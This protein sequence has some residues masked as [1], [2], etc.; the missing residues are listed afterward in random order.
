[1]FGLKIHAFLFVWSNLLFLYLYL[2]ES[3][4]FQEGEKPDKIISSK[5]NIGGKLQMDASKGNTG[6]FMNGREITKIELR[7]LKVNSFSPCICLFPFPNVQ[8]II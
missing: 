5:L 6:V 1:M 2:P 7:M 3:N 4:G 8:Y